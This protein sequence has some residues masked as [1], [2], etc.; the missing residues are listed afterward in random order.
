M[1]DRRTDGVAV[2]GR[3]IV[4]N[5]VVADAEGG[6]HFGGVE[7]V[8]G[9]PIGER[10]GGQHLLAR[11]LGEAAVAGEA[12]E[13]GEGGDAF[14][15][16]A[17]GVE[18][19]ALGAADFV[20]ARRGREQLQAIGEHLL[21]NGGRG[22]IGADGVSNGGQVAVQDQEAGMAG[23]QDAR[24]RLAG[25]ERGGPKENGEEAQEAETERVQ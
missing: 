14:L 17:R 13:G 9:I 8:S 12:V 19:G 24:R 7:E 16:V 22:G 18:E 21:V 20:L 25:E 23:A 5:P 3:E 10:G 6:G 11:A 1:P 2:G 4:V 15:Y